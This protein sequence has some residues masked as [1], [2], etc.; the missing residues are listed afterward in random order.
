MDIQT[1]DI[2]RLVTVYPDKSGI[3]WWTK[4][5]FNR[6][7][8]GEAAVEI[9]RELAIRFMANNVEKD[10]WLEEYYPE[11]MKVYHQAIEQTRQQLLGI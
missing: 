1:F 4:C 8:E 9:T 2:P 5:W 10:A 3:R 11:Q 6:R 7:E